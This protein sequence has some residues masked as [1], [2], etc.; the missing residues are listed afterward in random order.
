M[1]S[2]RMPTP[3]DEAVPLTRPGQSKRRAATPDEEPTP[4]GRSGQKRAAPA[5]DDEDVAIPLGRPGARPASQRKDASSD[6][7]AVPL[8]R[9]GARLM[10]SSE[11]EDAT[12]LGRSKAFVTKRARYEEGDGD[13]AVSLGRP[14]ARTSNDTEAVPLAR[15][16]ARRPLPFNTFEDADAAT[17]TAAL[18]A[19]AS[20][21]HSSPGVNS[22]PNTASSS[23]HGEAATPLVF[24]KRPDGTTMAVPDPSGPVRP[25]GRPKTTPAGESR[26]QTAARKRAEYRELHGT[27]PRK[28]RK[29]RSDAG[30]KRPKRT[31]D[32]VS[33]D[34]E[35]SGTESDTES[36]AQKSSKG[37]K[38]KGIPN[39]HL[40]VD[41]LDANDMIGEEVDLRHMSMADL[42]R[43]HDYG[44]IS[45]RAITIQKR[46]AELHPA[47]EE[48]RKRALAQK[49][50]ALR[51]G[52]IRQV[53]IRNY[54]RQQRRLEVEQG[55][56]TEEDR[57]NGVSDDEEIIEVDADEEDDF[58]D[59][60]D[61]DAMA[62]RKRRRAALLAVNDTS[63]AAAAPEAPEEP[64]EELD[65]DAQLENMEFEDH[66]DAHYYDPER[67]EW[68]YPE[69]ERMAIARQQRD[70]ELDEEINDSEAEAEEIRDTDTWVNQAS[71][72][73][74]G[75]AA[76]GRK[77]NKQ[78]TEA[79]YMVSYLADKC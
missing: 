3:E 77:W 73:P 76:R 56:A 14:G 42:T 57:E 59:D 60:G 71:F 25:R 47:K 26:A 22:I 11:N 38:R 37:K 65:L 23:R 63:K 4:I 79:L 72:L 67:D 53:K 9:P 52:E 54:M 61:E 8:G 68:V 44:R 69:L 48:A 21:P 27:P 58:V 31:R 20:Q 66:E 30:T 16:G 19:T 17:L 46:K 74:K 70:Q 75:K 34:G 55:I 64:E 43:A 35:E 39:D 10:Q 49:A 33:D 50:A 18:D 40:D 62:E 1:G 24:K 45:G 2:K 6:E 32:S 7:E 12:P 36:V 51:K 5:E 78:E 28:A 41:G 29:Q 15:P 13:E